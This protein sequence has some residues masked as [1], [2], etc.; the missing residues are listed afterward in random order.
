MR[1]RRVTCR[2]LAV[3]GAAVLLVLAG[4]GAAFAS[5]TSTT[6]A[7]MTVGS[8]TLQPPTGFKVALICNGNHAEMTLQWT[9]TASQYA[10]GYTLQYTRN[11]MHPTVVTLDSRATVKYTD[12]LPKGGTYTFALVSTY[13]SWTSEP[14]GAAATYRCT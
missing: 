9:A 8:N 7:T 6:S 1:D 13:K 2:L 14:V 10:T 12:S 5:F 11:G 3:L 4:S